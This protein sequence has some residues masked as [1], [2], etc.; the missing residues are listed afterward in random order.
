MQNIEDDSLLFTVK[1]KPLLLK[2]FLFLPF[3]PRFPS[4]GSGQS[5][6]SFFFFLLLHFVLIVPS[7]VFVFA[8]VTTVG[9]F[10]KWI[11]E[12]A[13]DSEAKGSD[14]RS[15]QWTTGFPG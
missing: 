10:L 5:L 13:L 6:G 4:S 7:V 8:V 14:S 2:N 3:R 1:H 12:H 9:V 11:V 15:S